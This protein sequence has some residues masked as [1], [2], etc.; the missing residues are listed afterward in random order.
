MVISI[1]DPL[2][3]FILYM[4]QQMS[5]LVVVADR[6]LPIEPYN[7]FFSFEIATSSYHMKI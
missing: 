5:V 6:Q 1:V 4:A 3:L 7:V 2:L